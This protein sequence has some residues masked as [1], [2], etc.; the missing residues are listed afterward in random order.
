MDRVVAIRNVGTDL[1]EKVSFD[2]IRTVGIDLDNEGSNGTVD[3]DDSYIPNDLLKQV[4]VLENDVSVSGV[5]LD[6]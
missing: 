4:L 3:P 2:R 6:T 1:V 5:L